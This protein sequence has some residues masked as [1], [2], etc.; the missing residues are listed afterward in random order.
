[1]VFGVKIETIILPCSVLFTLTRENLY[2]YK[3]ILLWIGNLKEEYIISNKKYETDCL[4][5]PVPALQ[6]Q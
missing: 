1:M 4:N 3:V 5:L 6:H 2:M